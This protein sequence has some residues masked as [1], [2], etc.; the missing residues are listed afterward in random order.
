MKIT[1]KNVVKTF[2]TFRAVRGVSLEIGS[3]EL[4]A[5]L[6]P[7]GS[8]KT[9]ILRMVA[10]LEYPDGGQ[11][12]FGEVDAPDI[13]VRQ[14]GVDVRLSTA[15]VEA[16]AEGVTLRSGE[17]IPSRTLIWAAGVIGSLIPG[18][19]KAADERS[20]RYSVDDNC[21]LI[22]Y[23]D[24]YAL[25]DIARMSADP[26]WPKGHPQVATVAI[27][28]GR[29]LGELLAARAKGEK[30][31]AFRYKHKGSMATIGRKRAVVDIG[32]R[33]FGGTL[34]WLLWMFVHVIQLV[35]FRNRI[36][37]L[38]NW[39]WKY[40]SW[41]NTIRLIIRPYV[42]AASELQQQGTQITAMKEP[43]K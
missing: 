41:K 36:M 37:V 14:R 43:T 27:Q 1:L 24:V 2:Q 23:D 40:L 34:A 26:A 42:R 31:E 17:F 8:G 13:P 11:V 7:S 3:G 9:T 10:G 30:V 5:L 39:A 15:M 16:T 4:V 35:G 19:E 29:Y 25:G 33:T 32:K 6:G 28:Q 20:G 12:F 22:G 38:V 21:R 18:L